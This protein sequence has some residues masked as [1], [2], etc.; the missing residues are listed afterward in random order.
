MSYRARMNMNIS[1]SCL[2]AHAVSVVIIAFCFLN[3]ENPFVMLTGS[4]QND[5]YFACYFFLLLWRTFLSSG[6][7]LLNDIDNARIAWKWTG[8]FFKQLVSVL[9]ESSHQNMVLVL[10]PFFCNCFVCKVSLTMNSFRLF[11][12]AASYGKKVCVFEPTPLLH[13]DSTHVR[14][15]WKHVI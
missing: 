9:K 6:K 10:I 12:I 4:F 5:P 11:Q 15:H 7:Y 8:L 3:A 2:E 14:K 13:P 1:S